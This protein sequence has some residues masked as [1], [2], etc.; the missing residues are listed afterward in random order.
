TMQL[1]GLAPTAHGAQPIHD[2][3]TLD[4]LAQRYAQHQPSID[5]QGRPVT[6]P[7]PQGSWAARIGGVIWTMINR[8]LLSRET[9]G[10]DVTLVSDI[11][12]EAGMGALS[13]ADVAVALAMM[14]EGSDLANPL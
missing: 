1:R 7:A 6:P 11:P 14:P 8:Q 3:I 12:L 4:E 9:A 5:E 13:A 2:S 10:A